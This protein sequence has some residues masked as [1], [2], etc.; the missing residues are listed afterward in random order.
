MS[1]DKKNGTVTL[2][3]YEGMDKPYCYKNKAYKRSDSST[4]DVSRLEYSRLVLEGQNRSYEELESSKDDL[5]FRKL[6]EELR[7]KI[8][9]SN[10]DKD[11]LKTLELCGRGGKFNKAAEL[12]SDNN[13]F[14][15]LDIVRFGDD[16]DEITERIAI[17]GI[18]LRKKCG[19]IMRAQG[20]AEATGKAKITPAYNL[21][22]KYVLHTVA[23]RSGTA[24]AGTRAAPQIKSRLIA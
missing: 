16:I 2:Y 22:C 17:A 20:H 15:I 1:V 18:Q 9:L 8:E 19:D 12:I 23:Y 24:D 3:V 21:P 7:R 11:T 5:T 10:F 6:E 4:V 13:D 14:K